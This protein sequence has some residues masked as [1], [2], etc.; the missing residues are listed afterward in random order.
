MNLVSSILSPYLPKITRLIPIV[1][2]NMQGP[3]KS[4]AVLDNP[5]AASA[6][7]DA[8]WAIANSDE[9][10]DSQPEQRALQQASYVHALPLIDQILDGTGCEIV[11]IYRGNKRPQQSQPFPAVRSKD[12]K[13]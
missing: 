5:S 8:H 7:A 13:E 3:A 9:Q 6:Y 4:P 1:I 2:A 12:C 11:D 10:A